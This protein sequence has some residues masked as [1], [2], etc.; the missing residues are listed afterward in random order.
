MSVCIPICIV[1]LGGR[2]LCPVRALFI[3][4]LAANGNAWVDPERQKLNAAESQRISRRWVASTQVWPQERE[5]PGM[6]SSCPQR[7]ICGAGAVQEAGPVRAGSPKRSRYSQTVRCSSFSPAVNLKQQR[8]SCLP[9][10]RSPPQTTTSAL[11][12]VLP[13]D[14]IRDP[15]FA[16]RPTSSRSSQQAP[17]LA[18]Q[19]LGRR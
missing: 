12:H 7:A 10:P 17:R 8:V 13:P 4:G 6:R 9:A 1:P 3:D 5:Q 18:R 16:C 2:S 14:T 15:A 19:H 11:D